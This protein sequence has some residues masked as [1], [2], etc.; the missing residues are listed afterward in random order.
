MY[1]NL[2]EWI[3]WLEKEGELLRIKEFVDPAL[4][5]AARTEA[6]YQKKGGGKALLFE[7]TGTLYPV[8]TNMFGSTRRMHSALGIESFDELSGKITEFADTVLRDKGGFFNR[9]N[10]RMSISQAMK[11]Y[12]V[13]KS[14]HASCQDVVQYSCRLTDLPFLKFRGGDSGRL[15]NMGI[16]NSIDRRSGIRNAA[17]CPMQPVSED[18]FAIRWDKHCA[19][20]RNLDNYDSYR[21]PLAVCLGGDPALYYAGYAPIPDQA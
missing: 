15:M 2:T 14:G 5:I 13:I 12:P 19:I 11:W 18:T 6:E 17:V 4:D 20:A 16:V 8:I 10:F 7:N 1:E 21:M 9:L 3:K